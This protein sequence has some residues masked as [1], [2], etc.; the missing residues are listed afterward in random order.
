MNNVSMC[1]IKLKF[2]RHTSYSNYISVDGIRRLNQTKGLVAIEFYL[3]VI[4]EIRLFEI[5]QSILTY[6]ITASSNMQFTN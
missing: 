4:L 1:C 3:L 5:C 6:L 2:D